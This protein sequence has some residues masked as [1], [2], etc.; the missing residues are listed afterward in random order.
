MMP[1][2]FAYAGL[3]Y[4]LKSLL[5]EGN[6]LPLILVIAFLLLLTLGLKLLSKKWKL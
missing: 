4:S 2:G 5:F 3:G 1:A 6:L